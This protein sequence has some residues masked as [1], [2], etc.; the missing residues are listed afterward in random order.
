MD[1]GMRLEAPERRADIPYTVFPSDVQEAWV[2]P[3]IEA[4]AIV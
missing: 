3:F 1:T 4:M 2:I